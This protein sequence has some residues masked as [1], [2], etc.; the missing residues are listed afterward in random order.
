[1]FAQT[2]PPPSLEWPEVRTESY[3]RE[4]SGLPPSPEGTARLG[5]LAAWGRSRGSLLSSHAATRSLAAGSERCV[6]VARRDGAEDVAT[7][8]LVRGCNPS[9]LSGESWFTSSGPSAH[10]RPVALSTTW[11]G[12]WAMPPKGPTGFYVQ[13]TSSRSLLLRGELDMS[14]APDLQEKIDE[15]LVP[16]RPIFLDLAQLTFL[17][18]TGI[19]CFVRAGGEP[20]IRSCC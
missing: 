5:S 12:R 1:M 2:I 4:R 14:T 10:A 13:V 16:G 7:F 6:R 11:I 8:S 18:S 19:L 17:D 15:I 9:P 3:H 20:A